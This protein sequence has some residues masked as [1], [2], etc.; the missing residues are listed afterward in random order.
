MKIK[1]LR[2][3]IVL[4][5]LFLF[6]SVFVTKY[7]NNRSSEI[8]IGIINKIYLENIYKLK[9]CN[10]IDLK[11]VNKSKIRN[12]YYLSRIFKKKLGTNWVDMQF[13]INENLF[14]YYFYIE[15]DNL[16]YL[17]V[18][19]Y[20]VLQ[21]YDVNN[22]VFLFNNTYKKSN[23][24]IYHNINHSKKFIIKTLDKKLELINCI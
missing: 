12:E 5:V 1:N 22:K 24:S 2:K 20:K 21:V 3:Q 23:Y 11:Y 8:F 9:N 15:Q 16:N 17:K 4:F 19:K 13:D 18:N 14:F 6:L 10:R 7:L